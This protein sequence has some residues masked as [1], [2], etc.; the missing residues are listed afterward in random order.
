[1][2]VQALPVARHDAVVSGPW[3]LLWYRLK[4]Y[5]DTRQLDAAAAAAAVDNSPE[6]EFYRGMTAAYADLMRYMNETE[7]VL[8]RH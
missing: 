3:C 6:A 5:V 8:T 1:V 7:A 2:S 4:A